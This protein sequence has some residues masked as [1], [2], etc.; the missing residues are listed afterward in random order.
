MKKDKKSKKLSKSEKNYFRIPFEFAYPLKFNSILFTFYFVDYF[1]SFISFVS[2]AC[3]A[4]LVIIAVVTISN[5]IHARHIS[6][7][8]HTLEKY[9]REEKC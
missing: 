3:D 7:L 2:F 4:I 8:S 6:A 1:L 9:S 5:A